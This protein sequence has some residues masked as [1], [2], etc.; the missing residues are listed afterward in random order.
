MNPAGVEEQKKIEAYLGDLRHRLRGLD[1]AQVREVIE[2]MRSH[3]LEKTAAGAGVEAVLAALGSPEEL[4]REY[5]ADA[6]LARAESSGSP[7]RVLDVLFHWASLSLAG[8]L[9]LVI[10]ITGYF[11]GAVFV[12]L[13]VMKVFHPETA[14]VWTWVTGAG[15]HAIS[16]RMGFHGAPAGAHEVLGW[17]I[18]PLGL[19]AG[20]GLLVLTTRF[21][22]WC[23]RQCRRLRRGA[24]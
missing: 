1:E 21:A 8:Y 7:W 16:L 20:C 5:L 24:R 15:E 19:L 18:V 14:G 12:L 17:W 9:V 23:T 11:A 4:A 6:L 13:S 2:E 22:L 10:S 3:I